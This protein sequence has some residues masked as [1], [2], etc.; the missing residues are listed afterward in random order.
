M[1]ISGSNVLLTG[2]TGG[3][4]SALAGRLTSQGARLTV[5]GRRKE[6]LEAVADAWGA[7][8]VVADL[9]V[10]SDVVH[11]AE[12]CADADVL[13]ANAALPASGDLKDY[14][15][16]QLDRALD[17][18]LR[19]PVLLS[20]L[21]SAHMVARGRGH[22]VLVGSISGKAA[23][24][25]TSLY[26]ATKF[27]L[28]GF[29]LALRQELR[30]TGVGVSLVQPG[31]VRD[32]GMFAATG[33]AP[34]K[35]LRTV[36]PGQVAD[37]VVRAVHRDRCEVNVAPLELRLLSAVAGQFPGFAERVQARM[38][39]DGSVRQIVEAQRSHR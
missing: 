32:A 22:I 23:T 15:E 10:R 38:D 7:R 2:A 8:T 35:G 29:A 33:A 11:L 6:A 4:G 26:N 18:N 17:V 34:P 30:G 36:T 16:E 27:G 13:V 21:L 25:S 9:A 37:G 24:K 14:T 20:Q 19:A 12:S 3:I 31:F 39:F 1:D 28:R 5:S